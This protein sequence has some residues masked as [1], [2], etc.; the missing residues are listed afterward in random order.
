MEVLCVF[1]WARGGFILPPPL[2]GIFGSFFFGGGDGAIV[3]LPPPLIG[4]SLWWVLSFKGTATPLVPF[5]C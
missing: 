1:V 3:V 2:I 4:T 5:A